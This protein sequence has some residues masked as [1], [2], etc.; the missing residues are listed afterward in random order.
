VVSVIKARLLP[1]IEGQ[2]FQAVATEMILR[3]ACQ[4]TTPP[5]KAYLARH[6]R[7]AGLA[8]ARFLAARHNADLPRVLTAVAMLPAR[9]ANAT[10]GDMPACFEPQA[11]MA[12]LGRQALA[13]CV[14]ARAGARAAEVWG[15]VVH[16]AV[17]MGQVGVTA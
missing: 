15:V 17:K 14:G 5:L 2:A 7:R 9:M 1:F 13:A 10:H 4:H 11:L 12:A 16:K 3:W 6:A 8:H